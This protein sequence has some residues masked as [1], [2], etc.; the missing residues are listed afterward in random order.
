M[1]NRPTRIFQI[2]KELNISHT[3]ILSFLK[4]Q[5]IDIAS[6]MSPVDEVI[7]QKIL[8]EF[9]KDKENIDRIRK[10]QVRREIHDTRVRQEQQTKKTFKLLSLDD[11]RALEQ[12]E[13]KE[14]KLRKEKERQE[15]L[16]AEKRAAEEADKA[17]EEKVKAAEEKKKAAEKAAEEKKKEEAKKAEQK[18]K[19]KTPK[20]SS[21]KRKLRRIDLSGIPSGDGTSARPAK[22]KSRS[23]DSGKT[24]KSVQERV[25]QTLSKIDKKSKRKTYKK[26]RDDSSIETELEAG[27]LPVIEIPE[28]AS[29]DELA[30]LFSVSPSNVIQKCFNLGVLA[31]IN[32]RL[33]WDTIELLAMEYEYTA[34]KQSDVG[35]EIFSL[36]ETEE[37]IENAESR[38]AVV[39]VMGHVDHGKTSLLDYIRSANV[40]AGESGGITQHIGAYRVI[41]ESGQSITF[42]DTPGHEAFTAMRARGAQVTD[43]VILVVAADDSVMP[44]TIEAISHAK[45]AGSPIIVAINKIDKPGADI[46]KVKRELSDH[47]ILVEDWGGKIQSVAVSAKT[48]EGIQD[49]LN[50]ITAEAEL[51]E[52]KANRDTLARGTVVDSRLDKGHGPMATVLIQKGTLNIGDPFICSDYSGKVRAIMNERGQ[53]I[54]E[55]GPSDAVQILGF[56]HVPQAADIFAVVENERELKRIASERQRVSREIAQKKISTHSLDSMSAMIKKGAIK[57]LAL[58]IRGDVDGSVEALSESIEKLNTEEVSVNIVQ[59]SVGMISES[60][61]LLAEASHAV[62]IGFNVQISANAKLQAKQAGVEIR[63]YK[64]IYNALEDVKMAMEGLLEPE[65]VEEVKGRA[66]IQAQFKIPK[67]GFIAGAKVVDGL[68]ARNLTARLIRD[69]EVL[70][71]HATI[72][73]LKRFKDDVREVKDG[74]E[75]GIGLEGVNKYKEGDE[76]VVYEVKKIKRTLESN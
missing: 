30:K 62:I 43:I 72:I 74:L 34:E 38:A 22:G 3:E 37:D 67:I 65:E 26:S 11:Q 27:S 13:A 5:G 42:L 56:E 33:E 2:A 9:S 10:E 18:K 31:T 35:E 70:V 47:G 14:E 16:E 49:L 32:Q 59:K 69:D 39:T 29:V 48:G 55:A 73:S 50:S 15:K 46:D 4:G 12:K 60:D 17:K 66:V 75:C 40:V 52:L 63:S 24:Q 57:K 51:M 61:V 23:K 68:I 58:I 76:I 6:H 44:Q 45:A 71:D 28:F 25:R 19:E 20:I 1:G 36:D 21:K 41:L 64:I 8:S 54:T 53:R 7:H